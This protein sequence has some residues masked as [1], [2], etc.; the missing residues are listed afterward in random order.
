MGGPGWNGKVEAGIG[1]ESVESSDLAPF[2]GTEA[3]E[4]CSAFFFLRRKE[5]RFMADCVAALVSAVDFGVACSSGNAP[6][7]ETS[8][9]TVIPS[10][11]PSFMR[12][13]RS[14][15]I[16]ISSDANLFRLRRAKSS[17]LAVLWA[18]ERERGRVGI[19]AI[20]INV[21]VITRGLVRLAVVRSGVDVELKFF[22]MDLL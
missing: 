13:R 16:L 2:T 5:N 11:G 18:S 21:A 20:G 7:S 10:E 3:S 14:S 1:V 22:L 8:N 15:M 4:S 17:A 6:S 19:G 9:S 12:L